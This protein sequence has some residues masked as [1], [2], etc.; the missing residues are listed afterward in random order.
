MTTRTIMIE[1]KHI[2]R[3]LGA[4]STPVD[5]KHDPTNWMETDNARGLRKRLPSWGSALPGRS[6]WLAFPRHSSRP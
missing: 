5:L 2:Q 4:P 1:P 6:Q 3:F